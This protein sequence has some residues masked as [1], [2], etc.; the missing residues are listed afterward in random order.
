MTSPLRFLGRDPILVS[1]KQAQLKWLN[2]TLDQDVDF[3]FGATR[4]LILR[5]F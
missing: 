3:V 2:V 1:K 4:E 5:D